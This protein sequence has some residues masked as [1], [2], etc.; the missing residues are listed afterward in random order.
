MSG[1][2][3]MRGAQEKKI[4]EWRVWK[5]RKSMSVWMSFGS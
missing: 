4:N 5:R 1:V 2:Q 3:E